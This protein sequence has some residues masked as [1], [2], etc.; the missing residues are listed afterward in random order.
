V[1][2]CA[3]PVPGPGDGAGGGLEPHAVA[4]KSVMTIQD[5]PTG[6]IIAL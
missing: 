1:I 5:L 2:D 3:L 4:A 6:S